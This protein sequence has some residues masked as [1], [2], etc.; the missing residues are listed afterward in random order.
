MFLIA[1]YCF[2]MFL[3]MIP[4]YCAW[5]G[6]CTTYYLY[7]N[8]PLHLHCSNL[9]K[10]WSKHSSSS[11]APIT[12]KN[13]WLR[14]AYHVRCVAWLYFI[15]VYIYIT[16][17]LH[18]TNIHELYNFDI[19]WHVLLHCTY[20]RVRVSVLWL[21]EVML[22]AAA[23]WRWPMFLSAPLEAVVAPASSEPIVKNKAAPRWRPTQNLQV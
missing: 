1:S 14:Q 20:V 15:C 18:T 23:R 10:K 11:N 12:T 6:A 22:T 16:Y 21:A 8:C 13:M 19:L 17:Y 5:K 4:G 2:C 9:S 7:L 3:P